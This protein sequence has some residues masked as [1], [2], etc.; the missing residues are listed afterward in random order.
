MI[1]DDRHIEVACPYCGKRNAVQVHLWPDPYPRICVC[2]APG[3]ANNR[4]DGCG[5]AFAFKIHVSFIGETFGIE[6]Q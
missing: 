4:K 3:D 6:G 1:Q 2:D 5:K